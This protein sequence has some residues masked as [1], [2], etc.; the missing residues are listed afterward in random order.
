[1]PSA[2]ALRF[3]SSFASSRLSCASACSRVRTRLRLSD[4]AEHAAD[5]YPRARFLQDDVL[6]N[7]DASEP[8]AV[9]SDLS[10]V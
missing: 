2:V 10:V 1:M 3:P 6:L 8:F 7:A 9:C 4:D 5:D